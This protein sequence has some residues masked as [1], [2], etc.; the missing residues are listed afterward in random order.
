M[1]LNEFLLRSLVLVYMFGGG[2]E[3]SGRNAFGADSVQRDV[4]GWLR[5]GA[6][7][8]QYDTYLISNLPL[9]LFCLFLS[10]TSL[11]FVPF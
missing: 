4:V 9:F 8:V 10:S 3:W 7:T 1:I 11:H 5:S 2:A 6:R